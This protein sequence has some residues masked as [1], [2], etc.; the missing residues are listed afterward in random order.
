MS[1]KH[2]MSIKSMPLKQFAYTPPPATYDAVRV[3]IK[4]DLQRVSETLMLKV[5]RGIRRADPGTRVLV[6]VN[7]E[8]ETAAKDIFDT[9]GIERLLDGN[10][11]GIAATALDPNFYP[12][13]L[14]KPDLY[15]TVIAP[16]L[17]DEVDCRISV[18]AVNPG[19]LPALRTIRGL[20]PPVPHHDTGLKD[21]YF[22]LGWRF[23]GAVIEVGD[24]VV[25]GDD[26]LG[27]E[28]AALRQ[29]G[30]EV[31]ALLNEMLDLRK[32]LPSLED[33]N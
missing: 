32:S 20:I 13:R 11:Q 25:W 29:S 3:L 16:A 27:V 7:D 21:L 12:N 33:D 15:R 8:G 6:I 14:E 4:A 18:S 2:L 10:M 26:L 23:D 17:L 22:S 5:L 19:D 1:K 28:E 24:T 31:P 9:S 30:A